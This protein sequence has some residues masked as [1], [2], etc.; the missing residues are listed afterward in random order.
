VIYTRLRLDRTSK[1]AR[2]VVIKKTMRINQTTT[3]KVAQ[4]IQHETWEEM[5]DS[6]SK[7]TSKYSEIIFRNLDKFYPEEEVKVTKFD[8]QVTSLALQRLA[9]L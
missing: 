8:G 6:K 9:R 7:M 2:E 3:M 1:S 5:T 4:W